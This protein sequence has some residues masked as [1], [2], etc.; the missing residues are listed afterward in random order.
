MLSTRGPLEVQFDEHKLLHVYA[1][2]LKRFRRVLR[3]HVVKRTADLELITDGE[4]LHHTTD[5]HEDTFKQFCTRVGV[6]EFDRVLSD[7]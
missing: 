5:D 1:P 3:R 7:E 6:A 4:H 2:D